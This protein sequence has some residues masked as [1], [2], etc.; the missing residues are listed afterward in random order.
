VTRRSATPRDSYR[1]GG[2]KRH[3]CEAT[4]ALGVQGAKISSQL[5]LHCGI[6][7]QPPQASSVA[8]ER[9]AV[10]LGHAA[11]LLD[12]VTPPSVML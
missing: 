12:R 5:Q 11:K 2:E 10:G 7:N 4:K 9:Q 6:C 3:S 1:G 8:R